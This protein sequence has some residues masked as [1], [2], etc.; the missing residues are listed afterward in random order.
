MAAMRNG[1]RPIAWLADLLGAP[2]EHLLAEAETAQAGPVFLPY[3]T[4]E[5]TP[6]GDTK[7]RGGLRALQKPQK[8]AA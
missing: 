3:L 4:G 7:I 2:I 8:E 6:H 5:R 1:A